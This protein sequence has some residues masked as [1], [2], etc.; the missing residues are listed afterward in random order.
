MTFEHKKPAVISDAAIDDPQT[1]GDYFSQRDIGE[2][3]LLIIPGTN[4]RGA[5]SLLTW[6]DFI[7]NRFPDSNR[8]IVDYP[9]TIG[10]II[11]G[12]RAPRY[13]DSKNIAIERTRELITRAAGRVT[14]LGYSQGADAVWGAAVQ[15][16]ESGDVQAED[17]E[18][19]LFG[20]PRLPDALKDAMSK[21]HRIISGLFKTAF[22]AEMDGAWQ[23]DPRID[24]TSIAISGDP[25]T[26][27]PPVRPRPLR[28]T[29]GLIAG[30]FMVHGGMGYESAAQL[31]KLP[32][33]SVEAVPE[34]K[35]TYINAD[36]ADPMIQARA[37]MRE[38]R[39][40]NVH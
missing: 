39:Q 27:F 40:R 18:V 14:L 15:A 31:E 11:G 36:A 21:R 10:P 28:S 8:H 37:F 2:G 1:V 19:L 23:I 26:S 3:D 34:S 20:Y 33:N 6:T 24:V 9:A 5:T 29:A 30:Y 32:I 12:L 7:V 38:L 13:D 4:D 25:I 22:R 16:I 17:L 35:T